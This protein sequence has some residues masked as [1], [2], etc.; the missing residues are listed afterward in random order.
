MKWSRSSSWRTALLATVSVGVV[1]A[2]FAPGC[3]RSGEDASGFGGGS[4]GGN[5]GS[6][7]AVGNGGAS[8][9]G[10]GIG[11]GSAGGG[12]DAATC[13]NEVHKGQVIPL[14]M[15]IMVDQ[16]GSMTDQVTGPNGTTAQK[17]TLLVQA[18]NTFLNDPGSAGLGA[19]I[20]Y[21]PIP[22][23][24]NSSCDAAT[25]ALPDVPIAPLPGNASAIVSSLNGHKPGGQTPTVPAL[26]GA[27]DYAKSWAMAHPTHKVVVVYATDGD[28][29]GCSN[30]TVAVAASVAQAAATGT[31]PIQTYVI[32]IGGNL[33]SLG[34]IA[35]GGS[36]GQAIIVNTSQDTAQQL[37]AAMNEIRAASAVPCVLTIPVGDAGPVDF[38]KVNIVESPSDGGSSFTVLQVPD[39]SMCDPSSG[40]WYYDDPAAPTRIEL[41]SATCDSVTLDLTSQVDVQLGCKTLTA[42]PR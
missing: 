32:G 10:G 29:H 12:I 16:S 37:L 28:P 23:V 31:P 2:G 4:S 21:F 18:F 35:E 33:T 39:P 7:R 11:D 5:G 24:D 8:F 1:A 27:L 14:D 22:N 40:G 38:G 26:V 25:Y 20:G 30:D 17:W 36:T 34:Q 6:S 13:A 9:G 15:F 42:P 3:A 41:C 19:G